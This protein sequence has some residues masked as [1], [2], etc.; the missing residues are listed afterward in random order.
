MAVITRR[1]NRRY[2][3]RRRA[4]G[5][6]AQRSA[7]GKVAAS[8]KSNA[9][10]NQALTRAGSITTVMRAQASIGTGV[11]TGR[12]QWAASAAGRLAARRRSGRWRRKRLDGIDRREK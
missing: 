10:V 3:Q 11:T 6:V 1:P 9:E 7:A 5:E 8:G 2:N 12:R 4:S